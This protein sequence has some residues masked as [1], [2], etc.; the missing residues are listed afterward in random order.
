MRL[1]AGFVALAV[2]TAVTIAVPRAGAQA[3]GP[4]VGVRAGVGVVDATW[5]VGASAGQYASGR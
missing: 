3:R 2:L 5:H 4:V 1:R